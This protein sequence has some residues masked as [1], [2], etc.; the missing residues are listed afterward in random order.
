MA[1]NWLECL[2]SRGII[3]YLEYHSGCPSF[4]LGPPTPSPASECTPSLA[5]E[6]AVGPNS[7]DRRE[8]LIP[9]L[10]RRWNDNFLEI[11]MGFRGSDGPLVKIINFKL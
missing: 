3:L 10:L 8:S 4:E 9:C 7:D 5:G 11:K 2:D 1:F 6:G